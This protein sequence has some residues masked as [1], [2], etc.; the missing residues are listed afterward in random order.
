MTKATL[1]ALVLI[2]ASC[3]FAQ[4]AGKLTFDVASVKKADL[5]EPGK[6]MFMGSRGGPGTADPSQITWSN[7]TLKA[8]LMTAYNVKP[9]QVTGPDWIDSERYN[10]TA[11]VPAGAT[12]DDV[13]V[14][15]QNLLAE[16][17]G[18]TFHKISKVFQVQEMTAA[19]GGVKLK[20]T[21]LDAAAADAPQPDL[22]PPPPGRGRVQFPDAGGGGPAVKGPPPSGVG[23]FEPPK[24]DKNGIPQ[25]NAPGLI[26]MMT[27]GPSGPTA[28]MVG[29]AQT[30][31]RLADM[32]GNQMNQPVVDK[33][34]LTGKYDFVLEFAPEMNGRMMPPGLP[35]GGPPAP[36]PGNDTAP[37]NASEPNGATLTTALQQQLGLKLVGTKSPLDVLVID[38]AEK[39]PTE[40]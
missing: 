40:N 34:G 7:A 29:K 17:F 6:P 2:P 10:I 20:E 21:T 37:L 11:R 15:W 16:R 9:Y 38:K 19:K 28:R 1:L 39:V 5:P 25:L 27:M 14:M 26:M 23:G 24:L 36:P 30:T 32:L 3:A 33:T 31:E 12:K 22:Q 35:P 8:L 13:R 4:P 18:L